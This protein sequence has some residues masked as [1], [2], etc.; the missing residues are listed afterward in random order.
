MVNTTTGQV[1]RLRWSSTFCT[2]LVRYISASQTFAMSIVCHSQ[3]TLIHHL[4]NIKL[5]PTSNQLQA[6][7]PLCLILACQCPISTTL[8]LMPFLH[9]KRTYNQP[10]L[11]TMNRLSL[12]SKPQTRIASQVMVPSCFRQLRIPT[13]TCLTNTHQ[14]LNSH[15]NVIKEYVSRNPLSH[16]NRQINIHIVTTH[17]PSTA[18]TVHN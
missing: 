15:H 14:L 12:V 13:T 16:N 11:R 2:H 3:I 10:L 18:Q 8:H 1:S 17:H 4:T 7:C 6:Q 5:Q 9:K